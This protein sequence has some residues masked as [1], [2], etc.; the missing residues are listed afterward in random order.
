MPP[1]LHRRSPLRQRLP[2]PRRVL[3]LPPHHSQANRKPTPAPQPPLHLRPAP[4]RGPLRDPML[5]RSGPPPHRLE[6]D[7]PSPRWPPPLWSSNRQPQ[8][9]SRPH[10]LP[11]SRTGFC[12]RNRRRDHH[13][14]CPGAISPSR[15][16]RQNSTSPQCRRRSPPKPNR[17]SQSRGRRCTKIPT[18]P[19]NRP[20]HSPHDQCRRSSQ[21]PT[22]RQP[23]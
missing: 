9:S 20:H 14:P 21:Q 4:A 6:R 19:A 17:A 16:G 12:S 5:H 8:P 2:S 7:R 18:K 15:R 22:S 1:H 13:R 10:A 3:L 23:S 11:Q